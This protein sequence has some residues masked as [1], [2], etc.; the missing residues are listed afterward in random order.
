MVSHGQPRPLEKECALALE[1]PGFELLHHPLNIWPWVIYLASRSFT[2][3]ICKIGKIHIQPSSVS[4]KIKSLINP[5]L[6]SLFK[7]APLTSCCL[8]AYTAPRSSPG[9][10]P[11]QPHLAVH[12]ASHVCGY[13]ICKSHFC[14]QSFTYPG[15][16]QRTHPEG[17]WDTPQK[18]RFRGQ[19]HWV[20]E[21]GSPPPSWVASAKSHNF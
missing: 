8:S 21:P 9:S 20:R 5:A 10:W 13:L 12:A 3:L 17:S 14:L 19:K 4:N 18:V 11:S 1:T 7:T 16:V 2:F 15:Q 6:P